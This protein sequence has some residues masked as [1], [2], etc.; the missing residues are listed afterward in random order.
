MPIQII[1]DTVKVLLIDQDKS[2]FQISL[3]TILP[4]LVA[5]IVVLLTAWFSI[6]AIKRTTEAQRVSNIHFE[7]YKCLSETF[8]PLF[9]IIVHLEDVA[10]GVVFTIEGKNDETAYSRYVKQYKELVH[11]YNEMI[12]KH[13]LLLPDCI[14]IKLRSLQT[15]ISEVKK[16][17]SARYMDPMGHKNQME[18]EMFV[19]SKR[20]LQPKVKEIGEDYERLINEGRSYLGVKELKPIGTLSNLRLLDDDTNKQDLQN[21]PI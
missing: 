16:K 10:E 12:T 9:E 4:T 20:E 21:N 1:T 11:E 2:V 8:K 17:A 7:L 18:A 5:I 13:Q 14:F 3:L 19:Q 6:R 15:K